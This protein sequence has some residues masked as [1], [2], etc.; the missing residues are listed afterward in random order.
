MWPTCS[1]IRR[2]SARSVLTKSIKTQASTIKKSI[3]AEERCSESV[4]QVAFRSP[5]SEEGRDELG[6]DSLG[7]HQIRRLEHV[8]MVRKR[9]L[10]D[11]EGLRDLPRREGATLQETNDVAPRGVREGP[12]G[13]LRSTRSKR[14]SRGLLASPGLGRGPCAQPAR[15]LTTQG[16]GVG[17]A[18]AL[19]TTMGGRTTESGRKAHWELRVKYGKARGQRVVGCCARG[20]ARC[21]GWRNACC[22]DW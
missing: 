22:G 1:E 20:P 17:Y 15:L 14:F 2:S 9:A 6:P 5:R 18:C 13:F 4:H 19:G 21:P 16:S 7:S 12:E 10:G 8:E 11:L 3:V